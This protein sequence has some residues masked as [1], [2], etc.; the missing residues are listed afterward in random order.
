M[1]DFIVRNF[2]FLKHVPLLPHIFDSLLKLQ[3]FVYKRHLLDVFDSIEDEVLN[4]KGTTVNIHKYGG[5]QFNLYK[6]EIGHLHS[7]GLLDV[8]YSRKIKKVL[9]EEGRVSD[10]HL[11]KKSG[12][13]SFYIASPEDKAYAIKLLL[14]SYSIQTRNSSANLN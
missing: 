2:G 6:K 4:W 7:N 12:W 11:F 1:F 8:V 10:H 14:L 13:I 9:M 3:M 5:L